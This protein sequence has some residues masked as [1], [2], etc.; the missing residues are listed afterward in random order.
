MVFSI[1]NF[2]LLYKIDK[3]DPISKFNYLCD[4]NFVENP[5]LCT[6]ILIALKAVNDFIA[7]YSNYSY[8]LYLQ[9]DFSV[10]WLLENTFSIIVDS[11]LFESSLYYIDFSKLIYRFTCAK[12]FMVKDSSVNQ[13][14]INSWGN[15]YLDQEWNM[16][17]SEEYYAIISFF[18]KY[19]C[20]NNEVY[21]ELEKLVSSSIKPKV[22][23]KI[24]CLNKNLF[25]KILS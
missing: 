17:Y 25:V 15:Y 18:E 6:R 2:D 12:K 19:Y 1:K 11:D 10:K 9:D 24:Q 16:K 4:N 3:L 7:K 8:Y 5:M 22:A 14:R 23:K 13:L 21:N 20:K